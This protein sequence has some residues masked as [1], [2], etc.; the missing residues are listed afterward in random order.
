MALGAQ[1]ADILKMVI[2]EGMVLALLGVMI[3]L[4][5]AF[6]ASRIISSLLFGVSATD[7]ITFLLIPLLLIAVAFLACYVPALRATKVDPMVVLRYE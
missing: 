6:S 7:P 1:T 5:G 4:V 3:G 2:G